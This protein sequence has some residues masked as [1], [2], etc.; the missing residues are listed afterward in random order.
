MTPIPEPACDVR[1]QIAAMLD[2]DHPKLAVLIV[3]GNDDLVPDLPTPLGVYRVDTPVGV[4]LTRDAFCAELI[5][6]DHCDLHMAGVLGYP[7]EKAAVVNACGGRHVHLA[8]A[9]QAR[10]AEG[11]VVTEAFTSPA[12]FVRTVNAI[13]EH[14]PAGGSLAILTPIEAI[15]RRLTVRGVERA[16]G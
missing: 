16:H 5:A 8:R 7:E 10:D 15:A 4:L 1:A 6:E 14:V 12:G 2:V 9:V 13:T 11:S 3:P